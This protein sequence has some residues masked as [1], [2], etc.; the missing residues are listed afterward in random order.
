[1]TAQQSKLKEYSH[2]LQLSSAQSR[3]ERMISLM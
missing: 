2:W 3:R 1:V